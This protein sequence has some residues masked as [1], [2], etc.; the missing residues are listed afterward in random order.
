MLQSLDIHLASA[1]ERR[2]AHANVYDVWAR[3]AT[4]DE[5]VNRRD[6]S[7][8][9]SRGRWIVGCLD[10]RV[11]TSLAS[12]SVWFRLHGKGVPGIAIGSVHTLAAHRGR[13]FAP[14]LLQWT[15]QYEQRRGA[16]LSVLF[17]DIKPEYYARLG[18]R[19][20][21]AHR[22][23]AEVEALA[24]DVNAAID[25]W[26]LEPFASEEGRDAMLRM[27]DA[28]YGR[29][30]LL[31]EHV[32]EYARHL[33]DRRPQDQY[34]WLVRDE[35]PPHAGAGLRQPS[36]PAGEDRARRTTSDA[37]TT[38]GQREG[39]VRVTRVGDLVKIAD[40]AVAPGAA[41]ESSREAL[42]RL[43]IAEATARGAK[44]I[45]GWFPD[46]SGARAC[47][48]LEERPD[49]ITMLKS[50]DAALK[51]DETCLEAADRFVE[52]DHV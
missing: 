12:H 31:I 11:V 50:L 35:P 49:E 9:H 17:S 39:Y 46:S 52:I 36:A 1:A 42:F 6:A 24:T 48:R 14:R 29:E 21:P 47:F 38:G 16:R 4:V 32:G 10:G 28:D 22:G 25:G 45:G 20:C 13:G 27:Y 44:R 43:V 30:A 8:L 18:Y 23:W 40:F 37:L 19:R 3:G 33:E 2:A 26:R 5:H 7:P 34:F 15:E 41:E 51:L